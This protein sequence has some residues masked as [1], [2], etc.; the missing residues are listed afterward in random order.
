VVEFPVRFQILTAVKMSLVVFFVVRPCGL[1]SVDRRFGGTH[2]LHLQAENGGSIFFRNFFLPISQ[3]G[4]AIRKA[5]VGIKYPG[6]AVAQAP[7]SGVS[8]AFFCFLLH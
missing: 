2:C 4:V 5:S 3:H 1:A 8:R 6:W 7:T